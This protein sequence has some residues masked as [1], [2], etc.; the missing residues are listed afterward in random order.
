MLP[1]IS[2]GQVVDD[3]ASRAI[4]SFVSLGGPVEPNKR[5]VPRLIVYEA[6]EELDKR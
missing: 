3:L 5:N 4:F 6:V 2:S 1:I